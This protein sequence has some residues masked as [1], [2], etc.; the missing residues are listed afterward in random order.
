MEIDALFPLFTPF[1]F[2]LPFSGKLKGKRK[3][4]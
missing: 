3:K 4:G 2:T 1:S